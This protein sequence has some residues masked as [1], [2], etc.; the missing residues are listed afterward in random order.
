MDAKGSPEIGTH[1]L[2]QASAVS[3]QL[4]VKQSS[5]SRNLGS[6]KRYGFLLHG[7]DFALIRKYGITS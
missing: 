3:R 2:Q 5:C 6:Y 7:L 4:S 1:A